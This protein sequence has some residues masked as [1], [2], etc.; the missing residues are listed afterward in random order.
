M[1]DK[2]IEAIKKSLESDNLFSKD[3]MT[4]G[5]ASIFTDIVFD[6]RDRIYNLAKEFEQLGYLIDKGTLPE[7]ACEYLVTT[8]NQL[9][10][11]GQEIINRADLAYRV[12]K[13]PSAS[14]ED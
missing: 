3:S 2:E 13:M 1:T 10:D 7:K 8:A 9:H 12:V 6:M 11:I 4:N 14:T 5:E